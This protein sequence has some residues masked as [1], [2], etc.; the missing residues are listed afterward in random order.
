MPEWAYQLLTQAGP[1]ALSLA[2]GLGI[3]WLWGQSRPPPAPEVNPW[4]GRSCREWDG[5]E[6]WTV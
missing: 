5:R 3:G 1:Y 4:D 2:L 6:R